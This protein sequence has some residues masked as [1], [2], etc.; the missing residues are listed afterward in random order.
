[1]KLYT[2]GSH[3]QSN[4]EGK[5]IITLETVPDITDQ[6]GLK[7]F[8][9]P[10]LHAPF[11]RELRLNVAKVTNISDLEGAHEFATVT[12]NIQGI[13]N[14]I[15]LNTYIEIDNYDM[16]YNY[17]PVHSHRIPVLEKSNYVARNYNGVKYVHYESGL[18]KTKLYYKDGC[19]YAKFNH[20]NDLYNSLESVNQYNQEIQTSQFWY[21]ERESLIK[22]V[23]FDSRGDVYTSNDLARC[24]E[25]K[26]RASSEFIRN[27][28]PIPNIP[29]PTPPKKSSFFKEKDS[30][31][32]ND[33]PRPHSPIIPPPPPLTPPPNSTSKND[34]EC[35]PPNSPPPPPSTSPPS[36]I[37]D[38]SA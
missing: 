31:I 22:Q 24:A 19:I 20:R 12:L 21:D 5:V 25:R 34:K 9:G 29:P 37:S 18:I 10:M 32:P 8:K 6:K 3:G 14:N 4:T 17:I 1:M 27:L 15:E 13:K 23:W 2:L 33:P 36:T 26:R 30:T 7:Y 16:E 35:S 28:P 11:Y 38:S